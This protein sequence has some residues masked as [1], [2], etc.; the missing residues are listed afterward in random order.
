[1]SDVEDIL[2]EYRPYPEYFAAGWFISQNVVG[3]SEGIGSELVLVSHG[4]S[5]ESAKNSLMI[6]LS[7][8]SWDVYAANI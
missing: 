2:P 5:L 3:E 7:N 1:M 4:N 8:T 6:A